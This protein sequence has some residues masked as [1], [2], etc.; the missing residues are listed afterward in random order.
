MCV[1][2]SVTE[3]YQ[4]PKTRDLLTQAAA[5]EGK[6]KDQH[7]SSSHQPNNVCN[8]RLWRY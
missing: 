8:G 2:K 5:Q 1:C 4:E 7:S 6:A 3:E